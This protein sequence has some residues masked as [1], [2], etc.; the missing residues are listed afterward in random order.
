MKTVW[1]LMGNDYPE[2][3]YSSEAKAEAAISEHKEK[4]KKLNH[5]YGDAPRIY[6]RTYGFTVR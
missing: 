1:V 4:V 3:V 2:A 5:K 6:W